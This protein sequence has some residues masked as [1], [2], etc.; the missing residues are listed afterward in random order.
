M[1][2][3]RPPA[4]G[5]KR[6]RVA[7]SRC[8]GSAYFS[9]SVRPS[10]RSGSSAIRCRSRAWSF[11]NITTGQWQNFDQLRRIEAVRLIGVG[12][13]ANGVEVNQLRTVALVFAIDGSQLVE[14]ADLPL[15]FAFGEPRAVGPNHK[16]DG[17]ATIAEAAGVIG[18]ALAIAPFVLVGQ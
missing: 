11:A 3:S 1:C 15:V 4:K 13:R 9:S 7:G 8:N 16:G 5:W 6:S 17:A 18:F 12:G 10:R 14:L 2:S